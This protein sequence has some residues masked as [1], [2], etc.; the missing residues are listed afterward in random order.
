LYEPLKKTREE[1][2]KILYDLL[3]IHGDW[4]FKLYFSSEGGGPILPKAPASPGGSP[5]NIPGMPGYDPSKPAGKAGGGLVWGGGSYLVGERGPELFTPSD[6][7]RITPNNELSAGG[8]TIN[9]INITLPGVTNA[10]QFTREL[11]RFGKQYQ[12]M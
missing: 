6:T 4:S 1:L 5:P 8:I 7:G 3:Q 11:A 9:T 10:A 2:D 12:G